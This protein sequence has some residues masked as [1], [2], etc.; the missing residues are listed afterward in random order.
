MRKPRWDLG[1]DLGFGLWD[2]GFGLCSRLPDYDLSTE[3]VMIVLRVIVIV[4][5]AGGRQHVA[6]TALSR[7]QKADDVELGAIT[8]IGIDAALDVVHHDIAVD[9]GDTSPR[10]NGR[11]I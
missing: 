5:R 6:R 8:V 7:R 4:T 11:F 10:R 3:S 1:L 2:L 9:E